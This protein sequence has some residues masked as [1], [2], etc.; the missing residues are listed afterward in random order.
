MTKHSFIDS[1]AAIFGGVSEATSKGVSKTKTTPTP[2]LTKYAAAQAARLATSGKPK[3][4]LDETPNTFSLYRDQDGAF[5][6]NDATGELHPILSGRP[7]RAK[8]TMFEADDSVSTMASELLRESERLS[9]QTED[10]FAHEVQDI[11]N[12]HASN[13]VQ[14][15]V[16]AHGYSDI[17]E[18][19]AAIEQRTNGH[20]VYLNLGQLATLREWSE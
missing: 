15:I 14:R 1:L 11:L 10:L 18:A 4:T 20:W 6:L 9:E 3:P 13:R 19:L 2:Y 8:C 12:R 17:D 16:E 5:V 7:T